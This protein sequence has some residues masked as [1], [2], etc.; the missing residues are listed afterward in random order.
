MSYS[1]GK[2]YVSSRFH[3]KEMIY[4]D[5]TGELDRLVKTYKIL[6]LLVCTGGALGEHRRCSDMET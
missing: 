4:Y 3:A 1:R 2:T 6:L 5:L